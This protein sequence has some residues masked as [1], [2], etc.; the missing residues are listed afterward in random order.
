M[1]GRR[2][3]RFA[4]AVASLFDIGFRLVD[5]LR[6]DEGRL[7]GVLAVDERH[8][9]GPRQLRFAPVADRDLGRAFHVD[10]AVVGREGVRRQ[11]ST[12]PPDSTPR[13]RVH[14]P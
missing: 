10:A 4:F 6:A 12:S 3:D 9:A 5:R 8:Q 2:A 13:M 1:Y 14:Q 11:V 7:V